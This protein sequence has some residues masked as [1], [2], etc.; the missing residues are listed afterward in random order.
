ME[1][2][3]PAHRDILT[4]QRERDTI[5]AALR[6]WQDALDVEANTG[7]VR[8]NDGLKKIAT[9]ERTGDDAALNVAE[10]DELIEER[11]N[12]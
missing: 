4:V 6:F 11:L 8:I 5:I 1:M 7:S 9:N 12:V 10:I 2:E 3:D